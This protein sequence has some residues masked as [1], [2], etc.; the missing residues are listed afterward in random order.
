MAS[1][2]LDDEPESTE[3]LLLAAETHGSERA[4]DLDVD[5]TAAHHH[6]LGHVGVPP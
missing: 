3:H 5:I 4:L 2:R 6:D 1:D